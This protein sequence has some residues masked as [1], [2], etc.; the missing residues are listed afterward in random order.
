MEQKT[1]QRIGYSSTVGVF[2]G[3]LRLTPGDFSE[4]L[5]H[6]AFLAKVNGNIANFVAVAGPCSVSCVTCIALEYLKVKWKIDAR[7]QNEKG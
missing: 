5:S 3:L 4:C 1:Y 7:L 2:I 6:Q